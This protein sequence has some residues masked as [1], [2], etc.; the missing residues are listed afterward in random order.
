MRIGPIAETETKYTRLLMHAFELV[1]ESTWCHYLLV[2][3]WSQ[4]NSKQRWAHIWITLHQT[5]KWCMCHGWGSFTFFSKE[6]HLNHLS[7]CV[8]RLGYGFKNPRLNLVAPDHGSFSW[9]NLYYTPVGCLIFD[10]PF[11]FAK[12]FLQ[13]L[14]WG[15]VADGSQCYKITA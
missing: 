4:G 11:V 12:I 13:Q 6:T 9:C 14:L 1:H 2:V 7:S 8:D 3:N 15:G 5:F 10:V